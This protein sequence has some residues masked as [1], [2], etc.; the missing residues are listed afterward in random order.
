M[1]GSQV[2][3][4]EEDSDDNITLDLCELIMAP[5]AVICVVSNLSKKTWDIMH[6][7]AWEFV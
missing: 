4:G 3:G 2:H 1:S 6:I 5:E 7:E